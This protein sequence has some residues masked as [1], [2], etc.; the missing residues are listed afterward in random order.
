MTIVEAIRKVMIDEGKALSPKEAYDII[1]KNK[2]YKFNADNPIS[3]VRGQIRRHCKGIDFT[4]S[5][6]TKYFEEEK[7]G[8]FFPLDKPIKSINRNKPKESGKVTPS[9]MSV[10]NINRQLKD[11]HYKYNEAIK[12]KVLKGLKALTPTGFESFAKSL[13]EVYGFHDM[14]VTRVCND[15]GIDGYGKLRV[16]LAEMNVAFQCKR[17]KKNAIQ[18]PEVDKF[19]GAIQGDFEQGVF[20]TT[21]TFTPGAKEVSFKSGAV[22]VILIDGNGIVDLM[23]QKEF[24]VQKESLEVITYALDL[25]FESEDELN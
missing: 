7:D 24:G 9:T 22:P 23:V 16:G 12:Q 8:K 19:R 4:T 11:L 17:W 3:V 2:L 15:G 13:M 21:S 1:V 18:R 25:V 5:S 6:P 10:S 20:F 14:K